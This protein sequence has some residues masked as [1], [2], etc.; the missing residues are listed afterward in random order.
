MDAAALGENARWY[1]SAVGRRFM[2]GGLAVASSPDYQ[3]ASESLG[4]IA[5]AMAGLPPLPGMA[6]PTPGAPAAT[7]T[8]RPRAAAPARPSTGPA[9][10]PTRL[11]AGRRAVDALWPS[12]LFQRPIDMRAVAETLIAMKVGE[13][14]FPIPGDMHIDP[15]ATV[16][17]IA[18]VFDTSFAQRV[19]VLTRFAGQELARVTTAIEPEWKR[20]TAEAYAR[21][22]T[23]AELDETTRFFSSPAGRQMVVASVR[24]ME[25]PGL[26]RAMIQL[27]P[28]FMSQFAAIEQRVTQATAHLP[29]TFAPA[30]P[31]AE[32]HSEHA[33]HDED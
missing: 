2:A 19:P 25:D 5:A 29:P 11:A 21:E 6:T 1:E 18:S 27:V 7:V 31:K 3:R 17:Q 10:D 23:V 28:R 22:F 24:A 12:E 8:A 20:L 26:V 32:D 33:D 14:G 15:N 4:P 13:F 30:E 9:I 16:M